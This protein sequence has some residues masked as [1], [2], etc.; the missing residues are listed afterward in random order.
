MIHRLLPSMLLSGQGTVAVA[1]NHRNLCFGYTS[2]CGESA[3]HTVFET[4]DKSTTRSPTCNIEAE[5]I[6]VPQYPDSWNT[7]A[8]K[9]P[10]RANLPV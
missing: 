5:Y 8:P 9:Q 4:K 10:S 3:S 2:S 7:T 6:F 1:T